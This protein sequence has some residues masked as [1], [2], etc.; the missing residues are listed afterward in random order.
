MGLDYDAIWDSVDNT[1]TVTLRTC[2]FNGAVSNDTAVTA[3]RRAPSRPVDGGL[4]EGGEI[5]VWNLRASTVTTAPRIG[6][7]G[8][9]VNS[10]G[11]V[12]IIGASQELAHGTRYRCETRLEI[13]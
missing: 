12:F 2:S 4:S 9:I 10:D 11:D 6:G 1:E 8:R 13:G 5:V 3:L 7:G